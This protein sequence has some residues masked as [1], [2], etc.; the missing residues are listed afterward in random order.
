MRGWILGI[1]DCIL[2]PLYSF[3]IDE[4]SVSAVLALKQLE[5]ETEYS[6]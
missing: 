2:K 1:Q 6:I 5:K 3:C 4:A